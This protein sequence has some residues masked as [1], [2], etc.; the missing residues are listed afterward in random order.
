MFGKIVSRF[1]P[2]AAL[3]PSRF[4][5][6]C[7]AAATL[8]SCS[9]HEEDGLWDCRVVQVRT[10][11]TCDEPRPVCSDAVPGPFQMQISGIDVEWVGCF[12]CAGVWSG[13]D[14]RCDL[15]PGVT[16]AGPGGPPCPSEPWVVL[17]NDPDPG[18]PLEPGEIY[19]G[20]PVNNA[21]NAHCARH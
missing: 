3:Q 5:Y 18:R 12:S 16:T 13:G 15:D 9:F 6:A 14:F 2:S 10:A 1:L 20:I 4:L 21:Y 11:P 19:A 8:G 7:V 17:Q